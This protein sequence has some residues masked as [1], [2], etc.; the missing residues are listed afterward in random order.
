MP[1]KARRPSGNV[2]LCALLNSL[3]ARPSAFSKVATWPVPASKRKIPLF[4]L[5]QIFPSLSGRMQ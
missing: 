3:P 4:V 5:H 1:P 2:N